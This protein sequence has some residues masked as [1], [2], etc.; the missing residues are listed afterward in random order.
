MTGSQPAP[1]SPATTR[2]VLTGFMGAGK[3]TVGK[4]LAGRLGWK[5][6]DSDFL[7][8]RRAE[9]TVAG[10]FAA[11]GETIFRDLEAEVI[12][13][14]LASDSEQPLVLA[15]G[16]GALERS[17][18]RN[19]LAS[20]PNSLVIF[21]EAPLE[22]MLARCAA[23]EGGPV[24][25]VLAD[26]ARLTER[27]IQRLTWYRQAHL[28]LDTAAMTPERVVERILQALRPPQG[29]HDKTAL[30]LAA[31]RDKGATA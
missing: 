1:G 28:T 8:E 30:S 2:I 7:V 10:I 12:R 31:P 9:M 19:L 3:T 27:W 24:R 13:K 29:A 21:L 26:R 4:L 23:D 16:G 18:T 22:T 14:A 6:L 25:P 11:R 5:F 17:A 20:I 15:L